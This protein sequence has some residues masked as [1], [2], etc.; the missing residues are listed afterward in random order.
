[1][2]MMSLL[3]RMPLQCIIS[4]DVMVIWRREYYSLAIQGGYFTLIV[5]HMPHF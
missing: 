4:D 3:V 2:T 1:M 5:K